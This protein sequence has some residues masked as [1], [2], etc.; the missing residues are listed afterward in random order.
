MSSRMPHPAMPD[1]GAR[2]DKIKEFLR[3]EVALIPPGLFGSIETLPS[4]CLQ[5]FE[6]IWSRTTLKLS[7]RNSSGN[8]CHTFERAAA[9]PYILVGYECIYQVSEFPTL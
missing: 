4:I 1:Y 3:K 7:L 8:P 2:S 5:S 9:T 6:E